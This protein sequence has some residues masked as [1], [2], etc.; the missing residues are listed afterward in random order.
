MKPW[1][2][3]HDAVRLMAI[4]PEPLRE[5]LQQAYWGIAA[6]P[7]NVQMPEELRDKIESLKADL[8]KRLFHLE[9]GELRPKRIRD[10]TA[11]NLAVSI[12]D[13][14]DECARLLFRA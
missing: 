5:R 6:M 1:E 7:P 4:S 8:R 10:S 13:I 12:C 9:S 11:V 2:N 3:F 14:R